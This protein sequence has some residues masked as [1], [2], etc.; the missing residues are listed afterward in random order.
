MN[1]LPLWLKIG[2]TT[3]T[4]LWAI[5]YAGYHGAE[6]F[7]WYCDL[8]NFVIAAALWMESALLI[9]WQAVSVLLVQILYVVDVSV[10]F[11]LGFFP[12]GATGF[13]F[14]E[15]IPLEI[16]LLS[17]CLHVVTPPVLIAGL[18]KLGYD[19]RALPLQVATATIVLVIS[20]FG[21]PDRNINWSWGPLFRA[22]QVVAPVLY[23]AVAAAGY[24]I[25]LY[26]PSHLFLSRVWPRSRLETGQR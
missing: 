4:L 11:T 2:W 10:R 7:L 21:G 19:R 9:S 13:M 24:A 26:I 23:L 1:H 3:W 16:R 5:A 15:A 18:G 17:L 6:N 20:Y 8:A 22:Q 25:L 14:N 12:I